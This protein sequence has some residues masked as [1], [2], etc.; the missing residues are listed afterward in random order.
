[1]SKSLSLG[2]LSSG[3]W[4]YLSIYIHDIIELISSV[5]KRFILKAE[6]YISDLF[7]KP[8]GSGNIMRYNGQNLHFSVSALMWNWNQDLLVLNREPYHCAVTNTFMADLSVLIWKI[9]WKI[10]KI[11]K[12]SKNP[13]S[14]WL[15]FSNF[16]NP[17]SKY[18]II[19]S[20]LSGSPFPAQNIKGAQGKLRYYVSPFSLIFWL[21][22]ALSLGILFFQF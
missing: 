18:F 16:Y 5:N 10:P 20:S 14:N 3:L 8:S 17:W 1:M 11:P 21:K 6:I 15:H 12:N 7:L 9:S 2:S 13:L 19:F 4:T 22:F